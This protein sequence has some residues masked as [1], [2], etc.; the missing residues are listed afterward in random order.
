M[1]TI[2]KEFTI[3][4]IEELDESAQEGAHEAWLQSGYEYPWLHESLESVKHFLSFFGSNI[5]NYSLGSWGYSF[6]D[7]K[8]LS[9]DNVRGISKKALHDMPL[10]DG[11]YIGECLKEDVLKVFDKTGDLKY[12]I[13]SAV[14]EAV[15][16][17]VSDMKYCESL[18]AFI[19]TA[20]ANEWV[21]LETGERY[22]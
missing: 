16:T 18:E 13:K 1:K 15:C 3:Y 12:S 8:E 22:F 19:E 11:F 17:I 9:N 10:S 4:T 21:F 5:K 14:G 20:T 2:T 6:I 7:I